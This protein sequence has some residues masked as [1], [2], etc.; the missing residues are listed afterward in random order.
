[1][2]GI[3]AAHAIFRIIK[4]NFPCKIAS[5]EYN[6]WISQWFLHDVDKLKE[7]YIQHPA[8]PIKLWTDSD[9]G[10]GKDAI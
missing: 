3:K 7:F 6:K 2:S 8:Q 10:I 1:M 4:D 9:R 5:L